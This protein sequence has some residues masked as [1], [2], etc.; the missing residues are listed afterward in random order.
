MP[1]P[2][3]SLSDLRAQVGADITAELQ[4]VDGL[5]RFSNLGILGVSVA[6]LSHQHYGYLAW[7]AKQS[8]PYTAT[9]EYLEAWAALKSVY[10]EAATAAQLQATFVGTASKVLSAD[11]EIAR[12]DGVYYSTI[13]E[14]TVSSAGSLVVT[15]E[16]TD[17]GIAS[18]A[19]VGTLVTLGSSVS[20][21]QASGAIT[22]VVALGTA[23]ELD[24]SLR[25]RMLAAYQA[26]A[27]GGTVDDYEDWALAATGVTRSWVNPMGAGPGT[28]V[29][30]V[31]FD[32]VNSDNNGF[33]TGTN[34]LSA[35]D[36]RATAASTATGDLLSVANTVFTSQPVTPLV[37]L[38]GPSPLAQDFTITGLT[39][40]TTAVKTAI[41]QAIA[42]VMIDQGSPLEGAEVDLSVINSDIAAISG[43]A[44]F[45]ITSPTANIASV[46]GYL[47]T[48][49]V[50][51][52]A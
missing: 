24:D 38:C 40:A 31:M 27:R 21:I 2:R 22:A 26:N 47:P 33:P 18:N 19:A 42:Q 37:Y 48:V 52:Y 45:V 34:G 3:P 50:I 25:T 29:V 5:L 51:T 32:K 1:Y 41:S 16:A 6:G 49:G 23:Q 15:I 43:T 28:V 44:G 14:A 11:F 20:G 8:N 7:I 12:S 4:T 9:D 35:T 17:T 30:Y 36:N 46:L 39:S 13:A 10:R